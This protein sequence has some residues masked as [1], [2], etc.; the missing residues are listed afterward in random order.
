MYNKL[1]LEKESKVILE[2]PVSR[3][4]IRN[5]LKNKLREAVKEQFMERLNKNFCAIAL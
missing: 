3:E 4:T 2:T 5:A 1:L